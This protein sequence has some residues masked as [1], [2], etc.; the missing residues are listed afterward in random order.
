MQ[1]IHRSFER[2]PCNV[3][4]PFLWLSL[5]GGLL[6]IVA[7][8]PAHAAQGPRI[9]SFDV[10]L[11]PEYDR[12]GM[13]VSYRVRLSADT[14]LPANVVFAIPAAVAKPHAVAKRGDDGSLYLAEYTQEVKGSNALIDV[15][16]DRR[17]LQLEY[18]SDITISGDRREYAFVWPGGIEISEFSYEVIQPKG[19]LNFSVTPPPTKQQMGDG[20]VTFHTARLGA[21]VPAQQ[22]EISISYHKAGRA[23]T[24]AAPPSIPSPPAASPNPTPSPQ[25]RKPAASPNPTPSQQSRAPAKMSPWLVATLIGGVVIAFC[26]LLLFR[27]KSPDEPDDD[28]A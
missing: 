18:Y 10:A 13:L 1:R 17:D 6:S 26:S 28:A 27:L 21:K 5:L 22:V 14:V 19:A 23:L 8:L 11:W 9:E 4:V 3:S 12:P 15:L 20:G 2:A 7:T 16:T 25:A 24:A